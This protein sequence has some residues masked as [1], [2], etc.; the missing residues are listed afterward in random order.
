[1]TQR[2]DPLRHGKPLVDKL[3]ALSMTVRRGSLGDRLLDLVNIRASQINGCAFC[4]D[5]HNKEAA[6]HGEGELRLHHLAIWPEST[7]FSPRERAALAW[8]EAVTRLGHDAVPDATFAAAREHFDEAS[9]VELTFAVMTINAWN[10]MS[11]AFRNVP[12]SADA[13]FGL[14]KAPMRAAASEAVAI[15]A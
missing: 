3:T 14:D 8:T 11:I 10:R 2:L 9:L 6:L 1:M 4:V 12:G 7:L 15:A 13:A 5:M